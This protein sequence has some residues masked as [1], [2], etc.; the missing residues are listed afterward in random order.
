MVREVFPLFNANHSPA[1]QRATTRSM[2]RRRLTY[3]HIPLV[4][5][6]AP[7]QTTIFGEFYSIDRAVCVSLPFRAILNEGRPPQVNVATVFRTR[8]PLSPIIR[9]IVHVEGIRFLIYGYTNPH[10]S[11]P[12]NDLLQSLK[13]STL[14]H[15]EIAV[16][17][18]GKR[19]PLLFR[20]QS[21]KRRKHTLA[22]R[23]YVQMPYFVLLF[24]FAFIQFSFPRQRGPG[25]GHAP[26]CKDCG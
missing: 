19:V 14:W 23:L 25:Y 5:R 12:T 3:L 18:L 1:T 21:V 16:F 13:P 26:S 11:S 20:P 2:T 6:H 9:T 4:T 17:V 8:E 22:V 24:M 15:G 7:Q 10:P